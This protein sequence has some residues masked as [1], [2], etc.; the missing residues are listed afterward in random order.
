MLKYLSSLPIKLTLGL[1]PVCYSGVIIAALPSTLVWAL[2]VVIVFSMLFLLLSWLDVPLHTMWPVFPGVLLITVS[3]LALYL[4]APTLG[5]TS[6]SPQGV[7]LL[8][9]IGTGYIL[10]GVYASWKIQQFF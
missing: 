4:Q 7:F 2:V 9:L 10:W 3:L 8:I 6:T 1:I 5:I